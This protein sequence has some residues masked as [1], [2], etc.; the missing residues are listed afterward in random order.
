MEI[1]P[2]LTL[3]LVQHFD[4]IDER[5]SSGGSIPNINLETAGLDDVPE[6]E[7]V[8]LERIREAQKKPRRAH[9][10]GSRGRN[11][12]RRSS[13]ED[14]EQSEDIQYVSKRKISSLLR[15]LT[16]VQL[17]GSAPPPPTS[18]R[19]SRSLFNPLS[20]LS[21]KGFLAKNQVLQMIRV[22]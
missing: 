14:Y 10:S 6:S 9:G 15:C 13:L 3:L 19:I 1:V 7:E 17:R 12:F 4:E 18:S 5:R 20:V 16:C 11:S 21:R 22:S 2:A 8:A